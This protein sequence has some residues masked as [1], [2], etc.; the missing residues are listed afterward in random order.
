M[1][2]P[3]CIIGAHAVLSL[4]TQHHPSPSSV[5]MLQP[6][7]C[8]NTRIHWGRWVRIPG[9]KIQPGQARQHQDPR[10]SV[11]GSCLAYWGW[12]WGLGTF[13]ALLCLVSSMLVLVEAVAV[14]AAMGG[15]WGIRKRGHNNPPDHCNRCRLRHCMW[16]PLSRCS[17]RR[18]HSSSQAAPYPSEATAL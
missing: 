4:L 2:A 14:V 8:G 12:D 17:G 9:S 16:P 18:R 6:G 10:A 3:S 1:H 7:S 13:L 11:M 5:S 15:A